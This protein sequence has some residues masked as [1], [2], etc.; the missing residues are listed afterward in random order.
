MFTKYENG[1][2]VEIEEVYRYE[3]G[4]EVEAEAVYKYVDGAE[5]EVWYSAYK[6]EETKNTFTNG[7]L[8]VAGDYLDYYKVMYSDGGSI[9]GSGLI[10]FVTEGEW[11]NPTVKFNWEGGFVHWNSSFTNHIREKAGTISVTYT[12][13]SGSSY[14]IPVTVGTSASSSSG[15]E[16]NMGDFERT[17]EGDVV[18]IGVYI[19]AEAYTASYVDAILEIKLDNFSID[20]KSVKFPSESAFDKQI[21]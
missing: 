19:S 7:V 6:M 17:I 5:E 2:E 12:L 4:A 20:G 1:A 18:S 8:E 9:S 3:N 15:I 14:E 10:K 16:Y 13:S 21:W 11:T